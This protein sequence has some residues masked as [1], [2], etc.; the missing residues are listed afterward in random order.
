MHVGSV[1]QNLRDI[2]CIRFKFTGIHLRG[3]YLVDL[4]RKSIGAIRLAVIHPSSAVAKIRHLGAPV[5]P[6]MTRNLPEIHSRFFMGSIKL[7]KQSGCASEDQMMRI[8]C[9]FLLPIAVLDVEVS[10]T[11]AF[12]IPMSK[13]V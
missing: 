7:E 2:G 12:S 4:M 11:K 3:R 5:C 9:D 13:G 8:G 1:V 6:R 10:C